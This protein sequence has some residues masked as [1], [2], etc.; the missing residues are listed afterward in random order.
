MDQQF[1]LAS[2]QLT[3]T[4]TGCFALKRRVPIRFSTLLANS[5]GLL[6]V[7]LSLEDA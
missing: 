1:L 6:L 5:I 4:N 2:S 7:T 3:L